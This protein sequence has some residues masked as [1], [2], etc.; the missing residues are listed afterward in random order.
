MPPQSMHEQQQQHTPSCQCK[1]H[2]LCS[3][4]AVLAHNKSKPL[5][6]Y[7]Q[8]CAS[9]TV[10]VSPFLLLTH[11]TLKPTEPLHEVV[12]GKSHLTLTLT[13]PSIDGSLT[14]AGDNFRLVRYLEQSRLLS[15]LTGRPHKAVTA[16]ATAAAGTAGA[17]AQH[18][19]R[20][21][22]LHSH[23]IDVQETASV[24]DDAPAPAPAAAQAQAVPRTGAEAPAVQDSKAAAAAA[25]NVA[26]VSSSSSSKAGQQGDVAAHTSSPLP[27]NFIQRLAQADASSHVSAELRLPML[28]VYIPDGELLLPQELA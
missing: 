4:W 26:S 11:T 10:A 27:L 9:A 14:D 24:K 19:E 12:T 5:Y 16:A 7:N 15:I 13:N 1:T 28:S 3:I 20:I 17:A 6:I 22:K 21:A 25:A 18:D 2:A 23:P 8:L